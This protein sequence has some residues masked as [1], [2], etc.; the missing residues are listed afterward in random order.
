MPISNH[1]KQNQRGFVLARKNSSKDHKSKKSIG[2][3]VK[4]QT[5]KMDWETMAEKKPRK[6]RAIGYLTKR[7]LDELPFEVKPDESWEMSID[8]I[9]TRLGASKGSVYEVFH[10]FE[11]LCLVTKVFWL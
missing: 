11:A 4:S 3:L 2:N 6:K 9:K 5:E 8:Q 7:I 1:D 10:V